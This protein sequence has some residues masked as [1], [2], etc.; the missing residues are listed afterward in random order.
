M[1]RN[2]P[3][4]TY[5]VDLKLRKWENFSRHLGR[6]EQEIFRELAA[7]A[8]NRRGAIDASHEADIGV[9]ILLAMIIKVMADERAGG[10]KEWPEDGIPES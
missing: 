8:R 7:A 9:A 6:R 10:E 1:G 5:R 4:T 2:I 3:S